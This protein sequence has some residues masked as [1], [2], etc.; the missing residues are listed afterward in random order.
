VSRYVNI[1]MLQIASTSMNPDL[2]ARKREHWG[3]M[4]WYVDTMFHINPNIDVVVAPE[5]Y[6]DGLDPMN[7]AALGETIPGPLTDLFCA[8]AAE[9]GFWFVPGSMIEV[10]P[11]EEGFYNTTMLI[12]PQ[13]EI[14]LKHRKMFIPR[15]MEPSK[16]GREFAVYEAPGIGRVGLMI[17]ADAHVPEVARN[18]T[19][20][21]AELI[22]KPALQPAWIGNVRNLVPIVQTRAIENQCFVVSVNHPAPV[23]MGHSCICDPDGRILDELE[24]SDSFIMTTINM[25]DV[26]HMREQGFL[27]C[28]PFLKMLKTFTAQGV[29]FDACYTG[30]ICKAPLFRELQGDAPM[31]PEEFLQQGHQAL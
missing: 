15:P 8:K 6:I 23:A 25:E 19:M 21:G 22:L 5:L 27:G 13:G 7:L 12:S 20:L 29:P 4:A 24:E 1:A 18:L 28:F 30:D 10:V 9:Y 3:K 31:T 2:E 16:P 26:R 11:G 14:V 17:C